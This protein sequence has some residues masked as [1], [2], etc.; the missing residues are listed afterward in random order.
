[1]RERDKLKQFEIDNAIPGQRL[2]DGGGLVLHVNE[3]GR[4]YWRVRFR[5]DKV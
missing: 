2:T 3:S 4:H 1:M 5:E